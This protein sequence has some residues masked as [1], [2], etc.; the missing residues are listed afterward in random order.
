MFY[1]TIIDFQIIKTPSSL[2]PKH[3]FSSSPP[4][5]IARTSEHHCRL[6]N[7]ISTILEVP[8]YSFIGTFSYLST[9]ILYPIHLISSPTPSTFHLPHLIHPDLR[10]QI[11][12][13]PPPPHLVIK[14]KTQ[15]ISITHQIP[16]LLYLLYSTY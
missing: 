1:I 7:R 4:L 13:F 15:H 8:C 11:P 14:T 16:T 2:F 12:K 6:F 10:I 3:W 9:H 5:V